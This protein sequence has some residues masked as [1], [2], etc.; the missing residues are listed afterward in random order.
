MTPPRKGFR[1]CARCGRSR[2][3][4]FFAPRGRIC[5]T[6]R[7]KARSAA[8][9]ESRVRSTYGLGPGEYDALLRLQGGCCAICGGTRKQR[10]SV[11]HCHKTQLVRGLL[12]RMCNG[13]LLTASRDRPATL[14]AAASYLEDPPAPRLIGRRFYQGKDQ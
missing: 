6:C 13:R 5:D 11:D 1:R 4:R 9:H 14:R 12:C 2:A 10:L 7:R 3:E 8:S